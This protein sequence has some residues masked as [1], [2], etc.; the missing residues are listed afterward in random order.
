[1]IAG[2]SGEKVC[3]PG[4]AARELRKPERF[5]GRMDAVPAL[6]EAYQERRGAG[7]RL[8]R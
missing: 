5:V 3:R 4:A 2:Q 7:E 8:E 6:T 1:M